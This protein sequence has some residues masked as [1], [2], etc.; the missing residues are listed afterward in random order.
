ME[1]SFLLGHVERVLQDRT[2]N[3]TQWT[4]SP[5]VMIRFRYG[6]IGW[7]DL[8]LALSADWMYL[9]LLIGN[10]GPVELLYLVRAER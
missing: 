5:S 1:V 3:G 9:S 6:P 2:L 10:I 7:S 4:I 8:L